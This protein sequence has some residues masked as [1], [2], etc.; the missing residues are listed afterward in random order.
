MLHSLSQRGGP[1][2]LGEHTTYLL[3]TTRHNPFYILSANAVLLLIPPTQ[4]TRNIVG[5][6]PSS[7]PKEFM[8]PLMDSSAEAF[9]GMLLALIG[10]TGVDEMDWLVSGRRSGLRF[11]G[12]QFLEAAPV[13]PP[14]GN[15]G[16]VLY[17]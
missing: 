8:P 13:S 14:P 6:A 12:M 9:S 5:P 17:M 7:H 2:R 11:R 15:A 16:R 4:K 3:S 1:T 10:G